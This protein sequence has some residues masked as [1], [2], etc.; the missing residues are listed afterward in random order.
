M[1]ETVVGRGGVSPG[2]TVGSAKPGAAQSQSTVA[3]EVMPAGPDIAS[4]SEVSRRVVMKKRAFGI[5]CLLSLSLGLAGT[6]G[7]LPAV[8]FQL[9]G[10]TIPESDIRFTVEEL[11]TFFHW[12]GDG[13]GRDTSGVDAVAFHFDM[14]GETDP[15][16][17]WS[18]TLTS[19]TPVTQTFQV[20]ASIGYIGGPFD[21]AHSFFSG[22]LSDSSDDGVSAT[23]TNWLEVDSIL[24]PGSAIGGSCFGPGPCPGV[25]TFDSG[26]LSAPS[27]ATG[28]FGTVIPITLSG[29]DTV[30]FSGQ[31]HLTSGPVPEPASL[32]LLA[33]GLASLALVGRRGRNLSRDPRDCGQIGSLNRGSAEKSTLEGARGVWG[34][35]EVQERPVI[36]EGNEGI[37]A[38]GIR[39]R[40]GEARP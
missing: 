9:D 28:T 17:I 21:T 37:I 35:G 8:Q 5:S 12:S 30:N 25:G 19:L 13:T 27:P 29:L 26:L 33:M 31:A 39:G 6:A 22:S 11:G 38:D 3:V 32:S 7:A 18:L 36:R 20:G 10:V 1:V 4:K 23:V 2:F 34:K 24:V 15:S 40:A 14:F 16:I